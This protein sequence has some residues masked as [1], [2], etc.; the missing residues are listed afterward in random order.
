M[1]SSLCPIIGQGG[2]FFAFPHLPT[3]GLLKKTLPKIF[4]IFFF[5]S[6][7]EFYQESLLQYIRFYFVFFL[8]FY[9]KIFLI[10]HRK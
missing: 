8:I 3:A 2:T 6:F 4:Q 1:G 9:K 5:F 10:F 7:Q